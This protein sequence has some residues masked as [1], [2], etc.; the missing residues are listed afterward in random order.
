VCERR[1][2]GSRPGRTAQT[3]VS[4]PAAKRSYPR[5]AV[6]RTHSGR[7][8]EWPLAGRLRTTSEQKRWAL[9]S[10]RSEDVLGV[11]GN[12]GEQSFCGTSRLANSLL[13]IAQRTDIDAQ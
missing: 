8:G 4:F 3:N 10:Q 13:P 7:R 6:G 2:R 12:G 9:R 5:T 1:P 11:S